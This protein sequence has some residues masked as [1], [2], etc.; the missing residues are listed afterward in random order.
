MWGV[1]GIRSLHVQTSNIL[2]NLPVINLFHD[3]V[4][5]LV[6]LECLGACESWKVRIFGPVDGLHWI[7]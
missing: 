1:R 6:C 3:N 5:Y 4:T 2:L 7:R